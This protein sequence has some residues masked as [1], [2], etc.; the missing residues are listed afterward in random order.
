M[1]TAFLKVVSGARQGLNVPLD[2]KKP[3][4]IGRKTGD[5]LL[6]DALVSSRHAQI[7]Y[8]KS[9]IGVGHWSTFVKGVRPVLFLGVQKNSGPAVSVSL[10]RADVLGG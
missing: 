9:A 8:G 2:D 3:L 4:V 6:D 10:T 1:A 5:L 7:L